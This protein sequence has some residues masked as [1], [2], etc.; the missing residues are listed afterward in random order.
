V[1]VAIRAR[2]ELHR[3]RYMLNLRPEFRDNARPLEGAMRLSAEGS[4]TSDD[5]AAQS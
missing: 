3:E 1:S 4:L 5:I 2:V